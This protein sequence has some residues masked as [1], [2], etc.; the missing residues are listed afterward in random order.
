MAQSKKCS[1]CDQ[2][3]DKVFPYESVTGQEILACRSCMASGYQPRWAI[4]LG[5]QYYGRDHVWNLIEKRKYH[6]KDITAQ[7]LGNK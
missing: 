2:P 7:E 5:A 3:K 1:V 6:G 4:I